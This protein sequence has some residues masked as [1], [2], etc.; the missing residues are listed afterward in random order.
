[1]KELTKTKRISVSVVGY[2]AIVLIGILSLNSTHVNFSIDSAQVIA[3]IEDLSFEVFPDEALDYLS[4]PTDNIRFVDLRNEYSFIKSHLEGAKNIPFNAILDKEN[5]DYFKSTVEDSIS[6]ILYSEDQIMANNAWMVLYQIG[7]TNT[8]VL[9]GGYQVISN[10]DFDP[11]D[12]AAYLL[13]EPAVSYAE[14][15]EEASQQRVEQENQAKPKPKK[16]IQ[17]I[18]VQREEEEIDEGGC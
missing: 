10:P 15:L 5:L 2:L 11:D 8:K 13:E 6:V 3:E 9:L 14:V 16:Q 1:M 18:P 4:E 17:I 12:M 7:I